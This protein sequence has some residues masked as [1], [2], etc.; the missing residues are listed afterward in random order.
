MK[1]LAVR[2]GSTATIHAVPWNGFVLNALGVS[3]EKLR[4]P[5]SEAKFLQTSEV[6]KLLRFSDRASFWHTARTAGIPFIRVNARRALW[7]ESAVRDWLNRRSVG[8]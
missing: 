1:F 7:E 3:N 5:L 2:R 8:R 6:M 4:G